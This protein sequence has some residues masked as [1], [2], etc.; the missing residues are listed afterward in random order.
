MSGYKKSNAPH[1]RTAYRPKTDRKE[2]HAYFGKVIAAEHK[3]AA[4]PQI[5]DLSVGGYRKGEKNNEQTLRGRYE[6]NAESPSRS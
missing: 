6:T 5:R 1:G 2:I 3:P 4:W